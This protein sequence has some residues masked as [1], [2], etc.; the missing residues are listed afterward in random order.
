MC[1]GKSQLSGAQTDVTE[2]GKPGV[3]LALS[4]NLAQIHMLCHCSHTA[5]AVR[6][7]G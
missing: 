2:E 5:G 1:P 7:P 6:P 3:T 4:S